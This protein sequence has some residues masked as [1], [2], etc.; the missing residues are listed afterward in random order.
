VEQIIFTSKGMQNQKMGLLPPLVL[1]H[2][3]TSD[4]A[5]NCWG[6]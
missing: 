5:A 6:V 3:E 2:Q 1:G 4:N